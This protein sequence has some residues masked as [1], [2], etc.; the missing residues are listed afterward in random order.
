MDLG[1][2]LTGWIRLHGVLDNGHK[3]QIEIFSKRL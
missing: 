1:G 3:A 2:H